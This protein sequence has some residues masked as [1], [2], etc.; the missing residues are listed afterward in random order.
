MK[1]I[2]FG[3]TG[4]EVTPLGFGGAP[5]GF[6][7]ES[8]DRITQILNLLLDSGVN[9][10]DTAHC[11]PGSEAAIGNA[12]SSRREE[13]VLVSKC[14]H[15]KDVD[16]K[17]WS[18]AAIAASIDL[19]LKRLKTDHIDVM[20]LHTCGLDTLR[21]GEPI[22]AVL[23]AV[24]AG[25]VRYAGY[26]G[27]NAEAAWAAAQPDLRV[28]ETSVSIAD[29]V[30]IDEALPL[31]VQHGKGVLAKRPIANACW[32]ARD[33][34]RG[35]YKDY[36]SEY[37][38]RFEKMGVAASDLGFSDDA[39]PEIALRF[40]LG[41]EG[42][43]CAIVGTTNPDNAKANIEAA[44]KGPL[45]PDIIVKLRDAWKNAREADGKAW[46]GLA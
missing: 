19:S 8:Q 41:Q 17:D 7:D 28:L 44:K 29:Q 6:L 10:I 16:G 34:Q 38:R 4:L 18:P 12:V 24:K 45:P 40:T 32:K 35:M 42:A 14:G 9:L 15:A 1:K 25:K 31:C 36:A 21:H 26:S 27:D 13:Y 22:D 39:W 43:V 5:V 33:E 3:D 23:K 11:Y 46:E 20:L 2:P 37:Q 30:N